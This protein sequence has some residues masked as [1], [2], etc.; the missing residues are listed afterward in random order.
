[1]LFSMILM[2]LLISACKGEKTEEPHLKIDAGNQ[3]IKVI[4]YGNQHNQTKEEIE[5]RLKKVLEENSWEALPYVALNEK[6]TIKTENFQTKELVITDY[7]LT[8]TG[9]IRYDERVAQTSVVPVDDGV[10]TMTLPRNLAVHLSSN[11]EDYKPGKTIR[12][13]VIRTDINGSSFTFAFILRSD[14]K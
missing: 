7:I 1:M 6:I 5:E 8:K 12:G 2:V 11:S 14:A 3:E 13:M 10:A 9:A 4:Y